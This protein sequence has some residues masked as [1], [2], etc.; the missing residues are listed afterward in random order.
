MATRQSVDEHISHAREVIAQAE[1]Q[2]EQARQ[3][4][5]SMAS[6]Y[7]NAQLLLDDEANEI[8]QVIHSASP[9]QRDPL[10]R[11]LHQLRQTQNNMIMKYK[12]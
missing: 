6:D 3:Q 1:D 5:A 12:E 8:E 4:K 10:Y 2:L 11:I 9:E 7:T